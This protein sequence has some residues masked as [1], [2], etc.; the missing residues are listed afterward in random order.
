MLALLIY[1]P[2]LYFVY[3]YFVCKLKCA[4]VLGY[5]DGVLSGRP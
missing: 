4:L 3:M 5:L 2:D 1:V